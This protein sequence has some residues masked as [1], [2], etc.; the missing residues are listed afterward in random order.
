MQEIREEKDL[1]AEVHQILAPV[2]AIAILLV[3]GEWIGF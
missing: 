3:A 2:G 1:R